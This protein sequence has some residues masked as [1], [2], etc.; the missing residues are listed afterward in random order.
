MSGCEFLESSSSSVFEEIIVARTLTAWYAAD[1]SVA[2]QIVNPSND[3]VALPE[4]EGPLSK[5]F[6]YTWY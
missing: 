3:G 1:G 2:V 5:A 6:T 4:L